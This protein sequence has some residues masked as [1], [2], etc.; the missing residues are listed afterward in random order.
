VRIR[1]TFRV[2]NRGTAIPFHHQF[3]ISQI[4]KGLII[5]SGDGEFSN[6]NNFG[7]SGL[8]GQTKVS[9][10]GLHYTSNR[11]TLVLSSPDKNFVDFIIKQIFNQTH[12]EIGALVL[13]PESVEQELPVETKSETKYICISPL[14]ALKPEFNSDE[15]KKFIEPGSDEF[16]DF[17]YEATIKRMESSGIDISKVKDIDRF[18]I[19]PDLSY[20]NKIRQSQKKFARIYPLFDQD[21]KFEVRG[22]TFPFTLY[23]PHE[24]QEFV[25]NSGL[26]LFSHKGFGMVDLANED[27][28]KRA[29]PYE[30]E[31]LISA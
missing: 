5:S 14:V 15:G 9:R 30:I 25:M 21:A 27:P 13:I 8:K 12:L 28:T 6:Y 17:I 24:V 23:A 2:K 11:V 20:I 19:V 31:Q 10:N 3:L 1:V 29:V 22:Y 7:F 18:Q 16:S 4:I 26:G